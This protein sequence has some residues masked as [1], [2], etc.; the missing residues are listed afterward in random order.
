[1]P[2]PPTNNNKLINLQKKQEVQINLQFFSQAIHVKVNY[3]ISN[4]LI[5]LFFFIVVAVLLLCLRKSFSFSAHSI[6]INVSASNY[7]NT[8]IQCAQ[9]NLQTELHII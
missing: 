8:S 1:M 9:K 2:P 5:Q 6:F 4:N 7:T 3:M